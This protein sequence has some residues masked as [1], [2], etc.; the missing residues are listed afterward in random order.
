MLVGLILLNGRKRAIRSKPSEPMRRLHLGLSRPR[1]IE[2]SL[3]RHHRKAG[4]LLLT[5]ALLWLWLLSPQFAVQMFLKLTLQ[6][7]SQIIESNTMLVLVAAFPGLLVLMIGLLLIVRPSL[8]KPF[9]SATNRWLASFD[10]LFQLMIKRFVKS[11]F[12]C[13]KMIALLLL[14]SGCFLMTIVFISAPR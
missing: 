7:I 12:K 10:Q 8:L 4:F 13:Q 5:S 3:Y 6:Y 1:F 14:T 11:L 9:E 2:K